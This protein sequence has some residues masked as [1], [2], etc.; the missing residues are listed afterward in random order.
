MNK[1]RNT[2]HLTS[3]KV[4]DRIWFQKEKMHYDPNIYVSDMQLRIFVRL[5][6]T[7]VC[8]AF[9]YCLCLGLYPIGLP[10]VASIEE[11]ILSSTASLIC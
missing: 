10:C 3:K 4:H 8:A 1:Y 11:T 5:L 9:D 7:G 6:T 2:K